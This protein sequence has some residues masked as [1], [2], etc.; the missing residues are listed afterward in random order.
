MQ[1]NSDCRFD[2]RRVVHTIC[3][4]WEL[5]RTA[6]SAAGQCWTIRGELGSWGMWQGQVMACAC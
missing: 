5:G 2:T 6:H 3:G 1:L 4:T